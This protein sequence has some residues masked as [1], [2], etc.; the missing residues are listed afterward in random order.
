MPDNSNITLDPEVMDGNQGGQAPISD[1]YGLPVFRSDIEE[2]I[3]EAGRMEEEELQEIRQQVFHTD[4]D[5]EA[6]ELKEI[7]SQV[8]TVEDPLS[9]PDAATRTES[10]GGGAALAL[11][12]LVA[13]FL[14]I[15]I[16]Y[17]RHRKKTRR[18]IQNDA[19]DYGG[20]ET[21]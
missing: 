1:R 3:Q 12:M 20:G 16:L 2:Q 5:K 11:E 8:F 21:T 19:Y 15:L 14:V 4:T 17:Q 6:E 7:R 18:E 10:Y 9:N 13:V